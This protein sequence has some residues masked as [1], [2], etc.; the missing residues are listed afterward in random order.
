MSKLQKLRE[1]RATKVAAMR[2]ILDAAEKDG[3]ELSAEEEQKYDGLQGEVDALGKK[4]DRL[5]KQ[6]GLEADASRVEPAASRSVIPRAGGP[7]AKREFD[8]F[9]EFMYAV[10]FNPNDQRLAY[11]EKP[12][13]RGEQRMDDGSSGGFMVPHQLSG[14]LLEVGPQDAIVRPR[15]T[16]IPAGSPPDA[17]IT[18]PALDQTG[19]TP[20]NVFGGVTVDWIGEGAEKPATGAALRE[21][22][23]TPQEVAGHVTVTDKL[24][25]NWQAAGPFLERLLRGAVLQAEDYAFL[26]GNG[27]GKPLG[28]INSGA[29]KTVNRIVANQIHREDINAMTSRVLMRGGNRVWMASQSVIPQLQNLRNEIGSPPVGD[30]ALV[31]NPD[32]RDPAGNQMLGGYP[33]LWN[34][35]LPAL[36]TKG[37]LVLADLS[38]YLI[39][40][41]SGP[42]VAASEHVN[43]TSNKTVIKIFWNV[44]GQPW[45]TAPFK[46]ENGYEVS[47]FVVLNVPG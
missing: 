13:A 42:F 16:V 21:I 23:L 24:L 18:M 40:D 1:E 22:K 47:P 37:D 17:G 4:I 6:E 27:V 11:F 32:L 7:E 46:E 28:L 9:G 29:T 31:W 20:A 43:F 35:R 39:K 5:A 2:G 30:G 38:Y 19:S 8:S 34:N 12:E 41:G 10:R 15:A 45:L 44:D 25:R 3:R 26:L 14:A 36:G 33:I